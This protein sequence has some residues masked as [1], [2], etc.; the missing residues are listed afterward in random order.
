[1]NNHWTSAAARR[2][3]EMAGNP[4]TI[5]DAVRIVVEK[6]LDDIACPP[7]NL[8]AIAEKLGVSEIVGE[9]L[10]VSGELRREGKKLKVIYSNF[11]SPTRKVFTVAHE[12]GHAIF[13]S[14]GSR[15]PR[16][17]K[18]LERLCDML[19]SEMLM[20]QNIF[21]SF[22]NGE[23]SVS[24]LLEVSQAFKT[25]LFATSIRYTKFK[26][27]I[28]VFSLEENNITWGCGIVRKGSLNTLDYN[29][30]TAINVLL[31]DQVET[32]D[33]TFNHSNWSGIWKL[34]YKPLGYGK[35]ALF[36]LQPLLQRNWN[37]VNQL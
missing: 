18:E 4:P 15:P 33:F 6:V 19:A 21:S 37:R 17:G 34:D 30:R 22:I 29:L 28:T 32:H 3:F 13:E 7:T 36:M 31:N 35:N 8:E 24:N 5:E 9:D 27:N 26:K 16:T 1:M 11:L 14:S 12:L 20:P 23:P 2:L 25:S 10:P